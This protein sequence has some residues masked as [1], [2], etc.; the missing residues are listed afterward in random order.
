MTVKWGIIGA[1]GIA[2]NRVIPAMK[3]SAQCA[4]E[5]VM[6]TDPIKLEEVRW[7]FDVPGGYTSVD[8]LLAHPGI[9]A[10]YIAS[11][12]HA[13]LEAAVKCAQAG[14]P[15]FIEKPVGLNAQEMLAMRQACRQ[16]GVFF[17]GALMM[18]FHGLH[19]MARELITSGAIGDPV[20]ARMD[21]SFWY[22][23]SDNA[24]RQLKSLGGGGVFMDLGP[25]CLHLLQF[26]TGRQ[27]KHVRGALVN[28]QTFSYEVEDSA[29][30]LL[31]LEGGLHATVSTHFNLPE[32]HAAN[33]AEFYG[34]QG[35]IVLD[36]TMGQVEGGKMICRTRDGDG[37]TDVREIVSPRE[38]EEAKYSLYVSELEHFIE[39]MNVPS[40]WEA[41]ME[42]QIVLQSLI[43][44]I[45]RIGSQ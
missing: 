23:P 21:F 32:G 18:G 13:H 10:V 16:N 1:G 2:V 26:V 3:R 43:D 6:R 40:R 41:A 36:G 17:D 11:P 12:V 37:A 24:W 19:R 20:A 9:D 30:V 28:T 45:Y 22:P 34:T 14:I 39:L 7:Q 8:E 44:D 35:A 27:V 5:A 15:A 29:T 25:H 33:R 42:E 31:E 4:V 38:P